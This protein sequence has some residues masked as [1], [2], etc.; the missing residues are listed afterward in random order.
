VEVLLV[1]KVVESSSTAHLPHWLFSK[2][3]SPDTK[4]KINKKLFKNS[5]SLL[6]ISKAGQVNEVF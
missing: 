1:K 5:L 4:N 2:D 3:K 6:L